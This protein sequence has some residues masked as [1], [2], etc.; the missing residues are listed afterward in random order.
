[1]FNWGD[2]SNRPPSWIHPCCK[3]GLGNMW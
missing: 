3:F 1:M 2:R